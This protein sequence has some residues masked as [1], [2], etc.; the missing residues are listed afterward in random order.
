MPALPRN[1]YRTPH[2]FVFRIVV[3]EALRPLIG[4]R[5]IKK[6]L[7]RDYREAV[8]RARTFA[9][10]AEQQLAAARAQHTLQRQ[11]EDGLAVFRRT[12]LEKRLKRITRVTSEL[13]AG[14]RS[15]WL[16]SLTEDIAWRRRGVDEAD[17][18]ELNQNITEMRER[19]AQALARG[20]PEPFVPAIHALLIGRGYELDISPEEER[21]LVLDVLPAVQEGYD[22]LAQR[23][24]GR[25]VEP[26]PSDTPPLPAVWEPPPPTP[27]GFGWQNLL[28]HWKDDRRRNRRTL[29][30][31]ERD[32]DSLTAFLPQSEPAT[33]TRT[34]VTAWLR[35]LRDAHGNGPKTLEKKGT[36]MGALF[37]S[38]LKDD[39][40]DRNP[41]SGYDYR[42]FAAR[43]GIADPDARMPFT[44][45]QLEQLFSND[46]LY[47]LRTKGGGGY[48]TRM[49]VA[50]LGLFSGARLDEITR[51]TVSDIH[52][53]PVPHL[54]I[55]RAKTSSSIRDVPLHPTLVALG[56]LDYCDA[57][58]RAGHT[59]LWPLL[60]T[61]SKKGQASDVFGKWFN[62]YI[63]NKLGMLRS[64]TFHSFR[65][66]FKDLCR[67]ARIPRDIHQALTGHAEQTVGDDY[68][69]GFS[70]GVK[71]EELAKVDIDLDLAK[72]ERFVEERR[73]RKI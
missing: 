7:G 14:L 32:L 8:S 37:S 33:L 51:L 57:V 28:Q 17:Y 59:S 47:G 53:N 48:H 4:K 72:P 49:W 9:A 45:P 56:F 11:H 26:Q 21:Q 67:N 36:L 27:T 64:V 69:Q 54:S 61:R 24:A 71:Y 15:L 41:F 70:I 46:G 22:I 42:R 5:E 65:H 29:D 44:R 19:I 1:C 58:K 6:S 3:P 63:H 66:T 52:R 2:G 73:H 23:Q 60:R 38:A 34:E 18:E 35:H 43:E 39:L 55:N 20:Q 31:V 25:L 12:P 62:P 30:E 50:L 13:A 68:G 10:E 40:L 16:S